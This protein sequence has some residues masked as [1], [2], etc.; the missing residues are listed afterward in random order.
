MYKPGHYVRYKP[1]RSTDEA[2]RLVY[3][4]HSVDDEHG[5]ACMVCINPMSSDN[6]TVTVSQEHIEKI[7]EGQS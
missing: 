5:T 6:Q 1:E 2:Q 7:W 4:V 3:V